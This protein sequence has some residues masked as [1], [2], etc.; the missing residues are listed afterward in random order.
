MEIYEIHL[1]TETCENV[2]V[3]M[4]DFVSNYIY[5]NNVDPPERVK[6]PTNRWFRSGLVLP[7]PVILFLVP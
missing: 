2:K 7:P 1:D 3:H 4:T 6:G 5:R